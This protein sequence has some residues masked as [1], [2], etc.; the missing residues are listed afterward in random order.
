MKATA[1]VVNHQDYFF[2]QNLRS[3]LGDS[4]EITVLAVFVALKNRYP[5]STFKSLSELEGEIAELIRIKI[6]SINP[7]FQSFRTITAY[8]YKGYKAVKEEQGESNVVLDSLIDTARNRIRQKY[9]QHCEN[10]RI[11]ISQLVSVENSAK[12]LAHV[13]NQIGTSWFSDKKDKNEFTQRI[14]PL[15]SGSI[16]PKAHD[17]KNDVLPQELINDLYEVFNLASND[18]EGLG[19]YFQQ[20]VRGAVVNA[21]PLKNADEEALISYVNA[22]VM[23]WSVSRHDTVNLKALELFCNHLK[24]IIKNQEKSL[25][26]FLNELKEDSNIGFIASQLLEM[27]NIETIKPVA[28]YKAVNQAY[29]ALEEDAVK[30]L[31]DHRIDFIRQQQRKLA[32]LLEHQNPRDILRLVSQVNTALKEQRAFDD[33]LTK[34]VVTIFSTTKNVDQLVNQRQESQQTVIVEDVNPAVPQDQSGRM[35]KRKVQSNKTIPGLVRSDVQQDFGILLN[36]AVTEPNL[37]QQL[38]TTLVGQARPE[39]QH[40]NCAQTIEQ[41]VGESTFDFGVVVELHALINGNPELAENVWQWCQ[42]VINGGDLHTDAF[43][44][45]LMSCVNQLLS[46]KDWLVNQKVGTRRAG[47]EKT[48]L[49][50][51]V[52]NRYLDFRNEL[53]T[54]VNG[55][56]TRLRYEL[57]QANGLFEMC[58]KKCLPTQEFASFFSNKMERDFRNEL[59]DSKESAE[60]DALWEKEKIDIISKAVQRC[61]DIFNPLVSDLLRQGTKPYDIVE[62]IMQAKP[63]GLKKDFEKQVFEKMKTLMAMPIM[64]RAFFSQPKGFTQCDL[65]Q[66]EEYLSL[67]FKKVPDDIKIIC[68]G[69]IC[70]LSLEFFERIVDPNKGYSLAETRKLFSVFEENFKYFINKYVDDQ[71][72]DPI[73][74]EI[75]KLIRLDKR[76]LKNRE[77]ISQLA[78]SEEAKTILEKVYSSQGFKLI[79]REVLKMRG[80]GQEAKG[81]FKPSIEQGLLK[82][83]QSKCSSGDSIPSLSDSLSGSDSDDNEENIIIKRSSHTV[84]SFLVAESLQGM[85]NNGLLNDCN[86][87]VVEELQ[88]FLLQNAR[89]QFEDNPSLNT[90]HPYMLALLMQD[91]Q[92]AK[93]YMCTFVERGNQTAAVWLVHDLGRLSKDH[94]KKELYKTFKDILK[95]VVEERIGVLTD[96]WGKA[97]ALDYAIDM[98]LDDVRELLIDY[99]VVAKKHVDAPPAEGTWKRRTLLFNSPIP[100]V[101][102]SRAPNKPLP[103]LPQKTGEQGPNL[104]LVQQALHSLRKTT[105]ADMTQVPRRPTNADTYPAQ[106]GIQPTQ[107]SQTVPSDTGGSSIKNNVIEVPINNPVCN[108]AFEVVDQA[109]ELNAKLKKIEEKK[110]EK[111]EE[112]SSNIKGANPK[113]NQNI[114][115]PKQEESSLSISLSDNDGYIVSELSQKDKNEIRSQEHSN[116]ERKKEGSEKISINS[117][118]ELGRKSNS[119]TEIKVKSLPNP[120]IPD[121][122]QSSF[123]DKE[124]EN[125]HSPLGKFFIPADSLNSD[126]TRFYIKSLVMTSIYVKHYV[127][128]PLSPFNE[129][130]GHYNRLKAHRTYLVE[131]KPDAIAEYRTPAPMLNRLRGFMNEGKYNLLGEKFT[132]AVILGTNTR[133][134]QSN[135]KQGADLKQ[136]QQD[137]Q[138]LASTYVRCNKTQTKTFSRNWTSMIG[139][140]IKHASDK[141]VSL[142]AT[143]NDRDVTYANLPE[144]NMIKRVTSAKLEATRTNSSSSQSR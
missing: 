130:R 49:E 68:T 132:N 110:E 9:T 18:P 4:H 35:R 73:M 11:R 91:N 44:P 116:G 115:G 64:L 133:I 136:L 39:F 69:A 138:E 113:L 74:N 120:T 17:Q 2:G 101:Q 127:N 88:S 85:I 96:K 134:N 5:K 25:Y 72:K 119:L 38:R 104:G 36:S 122:F 41:F 92:V 144:N 123:D 99:G 13:A 77:S 28:V 24:D 141:Y 56:G 60:I 12:V 131:L 81:E 126:N 93:E 30:F 86:P 142:K 20:A 66:F 124:I 70:Q 55:D 54:D 21:Q 90:L 52:S 94:E 100:E 103:Q 50:V 102:S 80:D 62:H 87:L 108:S 83:K 26:D 47:K 53:A 51:L 33:E 98:N 111:K 128:N 48:L 22:V 82:S 84:D 105:N 95:V 106:I 65:G 97:N 143:K 8:F 75:N 89:E 43:N 42:S 10:I 46:H 79:K 107:E 59:H 76:F 129:A 58:E 118:K 14:K 23:E 34:S 61:S 40:L 6:K 32:R 137:I 1:T 57:N 140:P 117:E 45:G 114:E 78:L 63:N 112:I 121:E 67:A 15:V 27:P 16:N 31:A 135:Q 71:L 37:L 109:S 125:D 29:K 3:W 7:Q 139:S 19:K